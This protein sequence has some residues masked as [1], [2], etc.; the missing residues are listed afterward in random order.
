MVAKYAATDAAAN[1][2]PALSVPDDSSLVIGDDAL[3]HPSPSALRRN[4]GIE[5][6]SKPTSRQ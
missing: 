3:L 4:R 6:D 5:C 2:H 1:A